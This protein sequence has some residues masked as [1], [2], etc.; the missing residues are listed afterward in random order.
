MQDIIL[1]TLNARYI[2]CSLGLRYLQ[3]NMGALQDRT[4]LVEYTINQRAMDIVEDLI[5]RQPGIVGF[6]VYIWN[7]DETDAVIRL[8][9][10]IRPETIVIIG[11]PEVSYEY[12][13]Q[14]I[15]QHADHLIIGQSD[16]AFSQTCQ[17]LL[18]KQPVNKIIHALP[19][20][21]A[22]I[23]LPYNYYTAD[24]IAHRILYVEASRGCPFKCEFCL[25]A[26]DKTAVPFDLDLFLANM[27][28]LYERGARHFKFVDRTFNLK[29]ETSARIMEFFLQKN[30]PDLFLHFELI[31]DHLPEKLKTIIARFP[32]HSLQFEVGIQTLNNDIQ[33]LI[34]RKQNNDKAQ[35]NLTWLNQNSHAHIH[36]DLI[37][38]LPG[39][40]MASFSRGLNQLAAMNPDEIQVGLLKRLRG[41]PIIRHTQNFGMRY[42]PLPPYTIL[43]NNQIDFA[44]MQRLT[45]FARYWDMIINSGRFKS[46][47]ELLLGDNAFDNFL[48]LCDWLHAETAQT[49]EFALERLFSLIHRF[50]TDV[51]HYELA[52]VEDRML[53]DY[54]RSGLK[55]QAKFSRQNRVFEKQ[56]SAQNAQRQ[57]RHHI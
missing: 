18:G 7:V 13:E 57:K 49:H 56:K 21:L 38:G 11:G 24:D 17:Q 45:R 3:A 37:I 34:S 43:C 10:T 42:N 35:E 14:A 4:Q 40:D 55:G 29:I 9:K 47:K 36:A 48:Q 32:P 31:P 12:D 6:G 2:H 1:T 51:K 33:Q 54:H 25:S 44:S 28:T 23:Q 30:D 52:T 26:L 16:L 20:E 50:L 8:L 5:A 15:V 22:D 46:S 39:E 19:F 41:T 53:E 27:Q